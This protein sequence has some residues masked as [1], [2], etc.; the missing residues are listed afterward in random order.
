MQA[1]KRL[2]VLNTL[3][4]LHDHEA[5]T[6]PITLSAHAGCKQTQAASD[7]LR[8]VFVEKQR[9]HRIT[10]R[11]KD[12]HGNVKWTLFEMWPAAVSPLLDLPARSHTELHSIW[13]SSGGV[14][15]WSASCAIHIW[16]ME[17]MIHAVAATL[18]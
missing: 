1:A 4:K 9:A 18:N 13:Y 14:C 5:A 7:A 2:L 6:R 11:G 3:L 8:L 15:V 17:Y 16:E 10:L 12:D